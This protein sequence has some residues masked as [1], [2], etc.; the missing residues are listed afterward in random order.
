MQKLIKTLAT[1]AVVEYVLCPMA[2]R[3][4][5]RTEAA[6]GHSR[7]CFTLYNN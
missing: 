6:K 5:P 7:V 1:T 3:M 4:A 2:K